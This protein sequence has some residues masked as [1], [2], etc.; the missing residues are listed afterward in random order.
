VK[1]GFA[2]SWPSNFD[3]HGAVDDSDAVIMF[4]RCLIRPEPLSAGAY[5]YL[6]DREA[7]LSDTHATWDGEI[8]GDRC[9]KQSNFQ[10]CDYFPLFE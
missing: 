1:E 7:H 3:G 9:L 6:W 2:L 4:F 8:P 10:L 5:V